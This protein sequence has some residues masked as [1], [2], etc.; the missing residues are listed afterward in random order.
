MISL[1]TLEEKTELLIEKA[2]G[3]DNAAFEVLVDRYRSQLWSFIELRLKEPLKRQVE[4]DDVFQE[5]LLRAFQGLGRFEWQGED[6]LLRWLRGITGNVI[7][8]IASRQKYH[9]PI[10]LDRDVPDSGISP[11]KA[12][13]RDERFDRLNQVIDDLN[14]DHRKVI[15]L[16]RVKRLPIK[17]IAKR[18]NRSPDAVS[19]LLI[20]AVQKLK[21]SFGETESLHLPARLL[22]DRE[23]EN[24]K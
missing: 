4:I 23:D 15:L 6:S 18:M 20:R 5:T 19:Q 14:P 22:N 3:G 2:Q 17:E 8:Q 21:E 24:G 12:L 9:K 13:R 10:A 7:L 16:A 1:M 11:S